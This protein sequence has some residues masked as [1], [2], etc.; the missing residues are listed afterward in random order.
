MIR[1]KL[2]LKSSWVKSRIYKA[3]YPENPEEQTGKKK[4]RTVDVSSKT[5]GNL[6]LMEI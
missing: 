4:I 5:Q 2:W 6:L 3:E 1:M